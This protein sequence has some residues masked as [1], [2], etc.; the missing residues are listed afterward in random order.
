[1]LR[2]GVREDSA[3]GVGLWGGGPGAGGPRPGPRLSGVFNW[4]HARL[5]RGEVLRF[6]R[7]LDAIPPEA[8]AEHTYASELPVLSHLGVPLLVAGRWVCA[9]LT[10]TARTY[11]SWTDE[12]VVCMQVVGQILANALHRRNIETELSESMVLVRRLQRRLEAE[13]RYLR[14]SIVGNA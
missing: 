7:F 12:D 13:N 14:E 2:R 8:V 9:L 5:R 4:Y 6:D 10:S 3:R 1:G 11:R